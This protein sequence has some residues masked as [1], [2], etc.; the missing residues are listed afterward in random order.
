MQHTHIKIQSDI[1]KISD[2]SP[3]HKNATPVKTFAQISP[4]K[5]EMRPWTPQDRTPP[6]FFFFLFLYHPS[7]IS[8]RIHFRI[9]IFTLQKQK[10]SSCSC[11]SLSVNSSVAS[12]SNQRVGERIGDVKSSSS[13]W[14]RTMESTL[15][16]VCRDS[17][18]VFSSILV[19]KR[20]PRGIVKIDCV[21]NGSHRYRH[22][23]V[24]SSNPIEIRFIFTES[25]LHCIYRH[26]VPNADIV[27]FFRS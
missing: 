11:L 1:Q 10:V 25:S 6:C 19:Y 16:R 20:S 9:L 12:T 7:P 24:T 26:P 22:F 23:R 3:P 4:P 8:S 27:S 18:E 5:R 15:F 17:F 13:R 14:R 21:E 2:K